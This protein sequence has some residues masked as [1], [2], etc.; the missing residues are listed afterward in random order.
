MNVLRSLLAAVGT[1]LLVLVL[2]PATPARAGTVPPPVSNIRVTLR[3]DHRLAVTWDVPAVYYSPGVVGVAR[4]TRGAT[5]AATPT[6][7]YFMAVHGRSAETPSC[8]PLLTPDTTYTV[9]VWVNDHGAYSARR[10]L[11]VRTLKDTTAPD[12][13]A[14]QSRTSA[15]GEDGDP[16]V[17]LIWERECDDYAGVRIVR[18]TRPTLTG[19]T[20]LFA[21]GNVHAYLDHDIPGT[22]ATSPNQTL[23]YYLIALDKAGHFA[24]HYTATSVVFGDR[25]I[26]GTVSGTQ[27]RYVSITTGLAGDGSPLYRQAVLVKPSTG[28][29]AFTF[30]VPA[31]RYQVCAENQDGSQSSCYPGVVDVRDAT[32]F[33][34]I[35]F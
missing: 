25:T 10:S 13:F 22:S 17:K 35:Q 23:Y 8:S 31:G 2:L 11:T 19:G 4:L 21:A 12:V 28:N 3:T 6:S 1:L 7:G 30:R 24:A 5:P 34:P 33:G 26:T 32:T 16:E 29:R 14:V 15:I 9:A 27:D 18:N 20:V